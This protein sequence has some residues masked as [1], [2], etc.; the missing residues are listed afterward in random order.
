M[1]MIS[2]LFNGLKTSAGALIQY[3]LFHRLMD[4]T[5]GGFFS[6]FAYRVTGDFTS[7]VITLLLVHIG[8]M[9][10]YL[11]ISRIMHVAGYNISI[12]LSFAVQAVT[13]ILAGL[14][15]EQIEQFIFVMS[16]AYGIGQGIFFCSTNLFQLAAISDQNRRQDFYL[17]EGIL[18]LVGAI[19]PSVAGF[20][21][22]SSGYRDLMFL[23]GVIM[24]IAVVVPTRAKLP[25]PDKLNLREL[26]L[27]TKLN[28]FTIYVYT[29]LL[30]S[31]VEHL[32][33]LSFILV[34]F[35]LL[36]RSELNVGLLATGITFVS[37]ALAIYVRNRKEV[38]RYGIWAAWLFL[39]LNLLLG[40]FW[41]G[42]FVSLRAL[43]MPVG[44]VFYN[45]VARTYQFGNMYTLLGHHLNED[46]IELQVIRETTLFVGRVLGAATFLILLSMN[47][48]FEQ[49]CRLI[50]VI[51]AIWPVFHLYL[52]RILRQKLAQLKAQI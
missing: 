18:G 3:M 33:N 8:L 39:P 21:I 9:I 41:N 50:I 26:Y 34:P 42:Y 1:D 38:D 44:L 11:F 23:A 6:I 24:V 52:M 27:T 49:I 36:G 5:I 32:R 15:Y 10:G 2:N 12:K 37:S 17:L 20:L 51:F 29:L 28:G 40:T 4:L 16:I 19:F 43:L 22:V 47:M 45:S 48:E 7:V 46:G 14:M 13:Y 25:K 31:F 30:E 35:L